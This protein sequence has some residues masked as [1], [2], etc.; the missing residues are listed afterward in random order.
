MLLKQAFFCY[1]NR[2]F[3]F[4]NIFK[5]IGPQV[6]IYK[7]SFFIMIFAYTLGII[8]DSIVKPYLYKDIIDTLS[9]S[10]NKEIIFN[11]GMHFVSLLCVSMILHNIGY[12]IGDYSN[13]YFQ[14]KV[15]CFIL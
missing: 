5:Y 10:G 14:S 11:Q 6:K 4:K 3:S 2:M 7:T 15:D 8:F 9:S 1:H 13:S 12:R